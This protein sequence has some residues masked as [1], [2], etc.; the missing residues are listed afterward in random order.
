MIKSWIIESR[1]TR[2]RMY[3][4]E[5]RFSQ[6]VQRLKSLINR[7]GL[8]TGVLRTR[9]GVVAGKGKT[10]QGG[11]D[12]EQRKYRRQFRRHLRSTTVPD[13]TTTHL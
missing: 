9:S 2:L 10:T 4:I 7:P 12:D 6:D 13:D 8:L 1:T 11:G 5:E 3:N